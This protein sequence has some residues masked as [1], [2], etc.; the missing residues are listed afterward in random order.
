MAQSSPGLRSARS[1]GFTLIELSATL[2]VVAILAAVLFRML[3]DYA[4]GA[5]KAA[6]EQVASSVRAGLHLR[7]AGMIAL[8]GEEAIPKLADQNPMEWLSDKPHIYVGEIYGVAPPELAPPRS[9]YF[10]SKAKE[11]VYRASRTRH[12]DAPRNPH[13]EIRFK[14]TIEQGRLAGTERLGTA[15]RGIRRTE[16]RPVEPYRWTA[17]VN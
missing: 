1:R 7:V 17:A 5:E 16:L 9:W 2:V 14:V 10:D 15:L 8:G 11:L 13:D 4:E 3:T 12:L 6:M